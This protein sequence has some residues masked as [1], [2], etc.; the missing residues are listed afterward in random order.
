MVTINP[1][2]KVVIRINNE[3][4]PVNIGFLGIAGPGIAEGGERGMLLRKKSNDNFATEW[5]TPNFPQDDEVVKLSSAQTITGVKTFSANTLFNTFTASGEVIFSDKVTVN[6]NFVVNDSSFFA[7]KVDTSDFYYVNDVALNKSHIGLGNVVN[8]EQIPLSFKGSSNGVAELDANGK[9]PLSQLNDAIL[10]QVNYVGGWNADTNSP[11]LPD[12]TTVKGDYYITTEAGVFNTISF[13]VGDWVISNGVEW[14][15]VANTD[16]VSSVFGRT[17]V[18]T[19]ENN[20]YAFSQISGE[21]MTDQLSSNVV[22]TP[23]IAN[24]AITNDKILNN[25]VTGVKISNNTITNDKLVDSTI[26]SVKLSSGVNDSLSLADSSLQPGDDISELNNDSGFLTEVTE[27]DVT[28]FESALTITE[29]QISDLKNYALDNQVVKLAGSQTITGGKT[30]NAALTYYRANGHLTDYGTVQGNVSIN[31]ES[32]TYHIIKPNGDINFSLTSPMLGQKISIILINDNL[33]NCDLTF[34]SSVKFADGVEP[35]WSGNDGDV[36]CITL[37]FISPNPF[38]Y[39][40][41][42]SNFE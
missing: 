16:A 39:L 19:A 12:P 13:E 9:V 8:V 37:L 14:S 3:V 10:G 15:K 20:D 5:F 4:I 11:T 31:F 1:P 32:G 42:W 24:N 23:K 40:A 27:S 36:L 25:A 6:D 29:S 7:G 21:I 28:Q 18:V 35:V 26:T 41:T 2:N 38:Y 22:T 33:A 17:G 34:P 30:F